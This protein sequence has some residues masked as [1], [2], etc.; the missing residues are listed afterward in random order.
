MSIEYDS[1]I[2]EDP[3]VKERVARSN[4][5]GEAKG[6]AKGMQEA[7]LVVVEGR[8]PSLIDLAR[9]KVA[10]IHTVETLTI[11]L[12][13]LLAAPDEDSARLLLELLVA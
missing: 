3:E 13:S 10:R 6:E 7:I 1:L 4:A 5:E 8:F 11:L 12:K 9:S 2:D